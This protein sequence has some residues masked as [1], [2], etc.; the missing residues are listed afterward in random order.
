MTNNKI[1]KTCSFV[2]NLI[3]IIMQAYKTKNKPVI[4]LFFCV[5]FW[6]KMYTFRF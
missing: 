3:I 5:K 2:R 1:Y 6:C 4:G